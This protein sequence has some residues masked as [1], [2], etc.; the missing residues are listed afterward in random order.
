MTEVKKDY[1][2]I[3]RELLVDAGLSLDD[4]DCVEN[5]FD[6]NLQAVSVNV[7]D[8][9]KVNPGALRAIRDAQKRSDEFLKKH[10]GDHD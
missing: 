7:L 9:A 3:S 4:L 6:Y 1:I 8:L 10:G 2:V 5:H